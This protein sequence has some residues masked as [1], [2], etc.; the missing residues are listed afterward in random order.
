M[1]NNQC[2]PY[3]LGPQIVFSFY[4][5]NMWGTEISQGYARIHVPLCGEIKKV[6]APILIPKCS[7]MWAALVSWMT[8]KNPELKDPKI[9]VDGGKTKSERNC[10]IQFF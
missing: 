4:G 3:T 9:L 5:K 2:I 1:N 10:F 6:I 8:D 7:N